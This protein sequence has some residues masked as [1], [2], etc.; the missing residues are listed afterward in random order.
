VNH[1]EK[2]AEAGKQFEIGEKPR[3]NSG[4]YFMYLNE[5]F[6][7]DNTILAEVNNMRMSFLNHSVLHIVGTRDERFSN[8]VYDNV[9][10]MIS[11]SS[12]IS[13]VGE[14]SRYRFFNSLRENIWK[15]KAALKSD[16][17]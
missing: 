15:R 13:K 14:K 3:H 10:N 11:K 7:G 17:P 12:L 1:F 5:L 4:D 2:Q 16:H 6:I 9:M 8:Y